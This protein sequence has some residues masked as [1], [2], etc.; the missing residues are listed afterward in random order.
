MA[1]FLHA[2]L[3]GLPMLSLKP[4]EAPRPPPSLSPITIIIIIIFFLSLLTLLLNTC[5]KLLV[6]VH[7]AETKK[8]MK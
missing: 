2:F 1:L 5:T 7:F 6:H 8:E 3:S 4:S